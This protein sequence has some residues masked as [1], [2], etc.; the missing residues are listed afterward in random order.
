MPP[1]VQQ[2]RATSLDVDGFADRVL[3]L[4][5]E[6]RGEGLI[7]T[8]VADGLCAQ[9]G[10]VLREVRVGLEAPNRRVHPGAT[11]MARRALVNR[12]LPPDEGGLQAA[13]CGAPDGGIVT[14]AQ[15]YIVGERP[16]E[17]S[18]RLG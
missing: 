18:M 17:T 4:Q 10:G 6:I 1:M 11:E 5:S 14:K 12:R 16:S 15:H 7:P 3:A 13:M 9:L 2:R 8:A